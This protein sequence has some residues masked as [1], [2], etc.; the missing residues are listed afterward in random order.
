MVLR[1]STPVIQICPVMTLFPMVGGYQI[2]WHELG[3]LITA[4]AVCKRQNL[5]LVNNRKI[6]TNM[7]EFYEFPFMSFSCL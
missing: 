3:L 4:V 7:K 1:I 2:L 6:H 5:R